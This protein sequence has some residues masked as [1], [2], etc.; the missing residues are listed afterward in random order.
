MRGPAAGRPRSNR[1]VRLM[2]KVAAYWRRFVRVLFRP[3]AESAERTA[4]AERKRAYRERRHEAERDEWGGRSPTDA[5]RAAPS[6]LGLARY[7]VDLV[8]ALD[9]R[10]GPACSAGWP[11]SPPA[12]PRGGGLADLDWVAPALAALAEGRALPAPFDDRESMRRS[13]RADPNVPDR[14]VGEATPPPV[15]DSP[16]GPRRISQPHMALPA[17][18]HAARPDALEAAVSAVSDAV[19][20]FGEDYPAFLQEV[21][22]VCA[23][24]VES[25][26]PAEDP[27]DAPATV[28]SPDESG[29][30]PAPEVPEAV[31]G[32]VDTELIDGFTVRVPARPEL[33]AG[34]VVQVEWVV[35]RHTT[36]RW[37]PVSRPDAPMEFAFSIE[38]AYAAAE[39]G[40]A[41]VFYRVFEDEDTVIARSKTLRLRVR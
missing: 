41:E 22:N 28:Q 21:R 27:Y 36:V 31:D 18:F 8:H 32:L 29:T 15:P 24:L 13:L 20:T 37:D 4:R 16:P 33:A 17:V 12:A 35:D 10:R 7:D 6:A 40:G 3:S 5:L 11:C 26:V 19:H 34:A 30:L 1:F 23:S 38:S 2:S 9:A 25:D 39:R 14:T